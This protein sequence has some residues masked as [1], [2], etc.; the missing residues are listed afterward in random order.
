MWE[1]P[2]AQR[3][4]MKSPIGCLKTVMLA[5]QRSS[6]N[7]WPRF[8]AQTGRIGQISPIV[9]EALLALGTCV[10]I[11]SRQ[12]L[13]SHSPNFRYIIL[14]HTS[15]TDHLAKG[16]SCRIMASLNGSHLSVI[17]WRHTM[18]RTLL[19]K[20]ISPSPANRSIFRHI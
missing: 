7:S 3:I 17:T 2:I 15:D 14:H 1:I 18:S 10:S 4:S 20:A 19:M 16:T 11:S 5:K 9:P 6:M 13:R 8:L 12:P